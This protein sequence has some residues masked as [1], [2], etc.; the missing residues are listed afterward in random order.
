MLS[1]QEIK[2]FNKLVDKND[3]RLADVFAAL[4]DAKRCRIYRLFL[5]SGSKDLY[6]ND[7]AKLMDISLPSASQHLKTLETAGLLHKERHGQKTT[8]K[9]NKQDRIVNALMKSVL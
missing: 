9:I 6:V 4:S 5:K 7:I 3:K 1:A 2:K 8:F